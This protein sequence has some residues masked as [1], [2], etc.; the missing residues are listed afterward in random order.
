M[1]APN[2]SLPPPASSSAPDSRLGAIMRHVVPFLAWI[3]LMY[4]LGEPAAWKYALRTGLCL[5]LFLGLHPWTGYR[6][7]ELRDLMWGVPVGVAVLVAWIG[8][9][10][11]WAAARMPGLQE[12]YLRWLVFPLGE[13][14]PL[15]E[16][17]PYAPQ[18]CG[19]ALALVRLGG[20]ALVIASIEEFFWRGF[21]YRWLVRR[22]FL[23]VGLGRFELQ[24]F[25]ITVAVFGLEHQRW[26]A[27]IVAGAAYGGLIIHRKNIWGAVIAHVVTNLLL[28]LYVL[29]SG[30]YT[31][32]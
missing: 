3:G 10:T 29:S 11:P 16:A 2:T 7:P 8:L 6:G 12:F 26:L 4:A 21:L 23:S 28:G 15:P 13:L 32:W 5:A 22:R 1:S 18:T 17:S 19:W 14:P 27:G 24:A 9:E 25:L 20:S 30:S 31:F